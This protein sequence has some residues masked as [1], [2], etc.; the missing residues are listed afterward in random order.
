MGAE[1]IRSHQVSF[2]AT[3]LFSRIDLH[4]LDYDQNT[5][6]QHQ[7]FIRFQYTNITNKTASLAGSLAQTTMFD[8]FKIYIKALKYIARRYINNHLKNNGA[9]SLWTLSYSSFVQSAK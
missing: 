4:E 9:T 6:I 3:D 2:E 8:I 7:R 1:L 5:A